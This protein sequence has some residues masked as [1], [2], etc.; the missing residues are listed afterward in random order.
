M[1]RQLL[2]VLAICLVSLAL[3][4]GKAAAQGS[5]RVEIP[6]DFIVGNRVLPAD[7]YLVTRVGPHVIRLAS[8]RTSVASIVTP[9][10]DEKGQT[11]SLVFTRVSRE[12]FL[13]EVWFGRRAG[14]KVPQGEREREALR[15][16][17]DAASKRIVA[18]R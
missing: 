8:H 4:A 3:N 2:I 11:P 10:H 12:Y 9:H 16:L 15:A 18:L 7:S 1:K 14:L 5:S 6:F 13:A 17:K